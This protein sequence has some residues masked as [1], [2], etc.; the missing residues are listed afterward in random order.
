M[1]G[2][3]MHGASWQPV[4]RE[5]L[6]LLALPAEEQVLVNGLGCVACD[7]LYDFDLART[8]ATESP[9]LS[10]EERR[11]LDEIDL[12]MQSMTEPDCECFDNEVLHRPV[13]EQLRQLSTE[14]LLTFDWESAAVKPY[15]EG[16]PGVWRRSP[17]NVEATR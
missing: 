12:V 15:I 14:A 13:W 17:A 6:A 3:I 8:V 2:S 4:L 10:E 5:A 11:L 7:L 1:A 9:R 16:Q